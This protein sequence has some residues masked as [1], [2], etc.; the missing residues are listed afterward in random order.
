MKNNLL[1]NDFKNATNQSDLLF[2]T[3]V[4]NK[5]MTI[6][7]FNEKH[8]QRQKRLCKNEHSNDLKKTFNVRTGVYKRCWIKFVF[9]VIFFIWFLQNEDEKNNSTIQLLLYDFLK[10]KSR[11]FIFSNEKH[12]QR[13][14]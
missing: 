13:F 14:H 4:E 9:R 8:I 7:F 11:K 10:T 6:Y 2:I 5:V 1:D 3:I 12:I